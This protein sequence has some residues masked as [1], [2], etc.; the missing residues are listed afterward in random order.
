M[1]KKYLVIPTY[2][3]FTIIEANY[4]PEILYKLCGAKIDLEENDE[5]TD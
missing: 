3:D 5:Y 2:D 1:S 4:V